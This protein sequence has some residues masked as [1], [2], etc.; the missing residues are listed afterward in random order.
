M[1]RILRPTQYTSQKPCPDN[2]TLFIHVH[3]YD[4]YAHS[5]YEPKTVSHDNHTLF[6][7]V[8]IYVS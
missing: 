2:H 3:T 7:H 4:S 5:E 8:N 6:I 1:P